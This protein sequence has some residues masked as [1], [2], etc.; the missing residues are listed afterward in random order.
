MGWLFFRDTPWT[1][2]LGS[3][4]SLLYPA[5]TTIGFT[6]SNPIVSILLKPLSSW[7]PAEFQFIGPWLA[8]CF[9]CQ[10]YFGAALAGLVTKDKA[11][12]VLAAMMFVASLLCLS[13]AFLMFL[14]EV[15]IATN[16]LRIGVHKK[17]K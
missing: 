13:L 6:D 17:D 5:G 2:P 7:L 1:F 14:I 8:F 9:I 15:R 11:Q 16:T 3:V 10:G 12:Q 4:P